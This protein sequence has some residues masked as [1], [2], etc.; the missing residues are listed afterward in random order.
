VIPKRDV[1]GEFSKEIRIRDLTCVANYHR[2]RLST[3]N[4]TKDETT[5]KYLGWYGLKLQK[6]NFK[7]PTGK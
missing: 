1:I 3:W 2:Q 4:K 6:G 5:S 7:Y